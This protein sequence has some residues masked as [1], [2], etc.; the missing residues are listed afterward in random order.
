MAIN[1]HQTQFLETV[2]LE[3]RAAN[4]VLRPVQPDFLDFRFSTLTAYTCS[5]CG[6]TAF[7]A[8][9]PEQL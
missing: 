9:E 3:K 7:Y 5:T 6:F 8:Q 1:H 4:V 2:F